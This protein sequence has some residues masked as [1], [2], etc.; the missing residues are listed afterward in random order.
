MPRSNNKLLTTNSSVGYKALYSCLSLHMRSTGAFRSSRDPT[1]NTGAPFLPSV[2]IPIHR[3]TAPSICPRTIPANVLSRCYCGRPSF[4]TRDWST[5]WDT[6]FVRRSAAF[7]ELAIFC[8]V[9]RPSA[10]HCCRARSRT[11]TC[12]MRP[13]P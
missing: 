13:R 9:K 7:P 8:R 11:C 1:K 12:F 3:C 6:C 10:I 5:F 2:H 4:G